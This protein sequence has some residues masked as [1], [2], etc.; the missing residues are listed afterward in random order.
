MNNKWIALAADIINNLS[1]SNCKNSS[2]EW[3]FP[4]SWSKLEIQEFVKAM[5]VDSDVAIEYNSERLEVEDW[6]VMAFLAKKLKNLSQTNVN[7]EQK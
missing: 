5:Y 7:H 2:N 3:K 6:W 4:A 1:E